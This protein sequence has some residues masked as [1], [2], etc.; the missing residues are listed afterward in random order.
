MERISQIQLAA[1][2]HYNDIQVFELRCGEILLA[3]SNVRH[4]YQKCLKDIHRKGRPK[5][6]SSCQGKMQIVC[7]ADENSYAH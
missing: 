1:I 2:C 7:V 3:S 4:M 5:R 6:C